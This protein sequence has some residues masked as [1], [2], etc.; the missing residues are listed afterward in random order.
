MKPEE[1]NSFLYETKKLAPYKRKEMIIEFVEKAKA[2]CEQ[3]LIIDAMYNQMD[4]ASMHIGEKNAYESAIRGFEETL[5]R[6]D[7]C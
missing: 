3:E 1:R 5:K 2:L 4:F 6:F 7:R